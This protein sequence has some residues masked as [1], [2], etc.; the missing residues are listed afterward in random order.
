MLFLAGLLFSTAE[1]T[2]AQRADGNFGLGVIAGEP[3]GLS[4]KLWTGNQNAFAAGVAWSFSGDSQLH[5]HTDYLFHNF[6][7]IRVEQG[8]MALHYGVGGRLQLQE[9]DDSKLG[10]RF[11]VGLSYFLANNP[12]EIFV[13][14]VPVLDLTPDT[15]FSGNGGLGVRYYF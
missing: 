13:E 5:L 9:D 4:A 15:E 10:V 14:V 7:L 11:P 1:Q 12:L 2:Q 8:S 3:T 6:N